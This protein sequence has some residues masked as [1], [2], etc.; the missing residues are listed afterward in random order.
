MPLA[1]TRSPKTRMSVDRGS[2]AARHRQTT[3]PQWR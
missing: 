2:P 3:E 1:S